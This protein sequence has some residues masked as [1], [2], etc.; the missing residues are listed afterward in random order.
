MGPGEVV[1]DLDEV[2]VPQH[3][4]A[5]LDPAEEIH[6]ALLELRL[7]A[8]DV[9]RG[10]DLGQRHA[11]LVAQ[12]PEPGEQDGAREEVVLAVG[13]LEHDGE[14]VLDEAAGH[15]HGVFGQGA[16]GD[17]EGFGGEEVVDARR[18]GAE[19]GGVALGEVGASRKRLSGVSAVEHESRYAS[20]GGAKRQA[21]SSSS[22]STAPS[23]ASGAVLQHLS[24][25]SSIRRFLSP[26]KRR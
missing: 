24:P 21:Y 19:E 18:G 9:A 6:H 23:Y 14:V 12:P 10:V 17:V 1:V 11:E 15:G 4:L 8:R 16:G 2:V 5:R 22:S 20:G 3:G 13:L 25:R 7:E 26:W